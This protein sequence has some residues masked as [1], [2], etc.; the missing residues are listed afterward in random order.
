MIVARRIAP[1]SYDLLG[2]PLPAGRLPALI[3][4]ATLTALFLGLLIAYPATVVLNSLHRPDAGH[5]GP[6]HDAAPAHAHEA[7][8]RQHAGAGNVAGNLQFAPVDGHGHVDHTAMAIQ[9]GQT[10]GPSVPTN[11]TA[12]GAVTAGPFAGV[13]GREVL[14][15]V[16]LLAGAL[17]V[18]EM[19]S[20]LRTGRRRRAWRLEP[21]VR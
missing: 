6:R 3:W 14:L 8:G 21:H 7:G 12:A 16:P 20:G 18:A 11:R 4:R 17:L 13:S 9:S 2:V 19:L 10:D 5:A 15:T 1:R